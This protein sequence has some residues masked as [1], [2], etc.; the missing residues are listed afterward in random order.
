M[1]G[2]KFSR[3]PMSESHEK[4]LCY[5]TESEKRRKKVQLNFVCSSEKKHS[6]CYQSDR[7]ESYYYKNKT[8]SLPCL[9]K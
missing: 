9:L 4:M 8:N 3:L 1:R 5:H 6:S 2:R 7:S